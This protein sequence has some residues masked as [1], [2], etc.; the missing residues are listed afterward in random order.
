MSNGEL[1]HP[2]I[3]V[4]SVLAAITVVVLQIVFGLWVRFDYG[5]PFGQAVWIG[6]MWL[7]CSMTASV[8]FSAMFSWRRLFFGAAAFVWHVLVMSICWRESPVR[9]MLLLGGLLVL[10]ST[11]STL[12]GVPAWLAWHTNEGDLP[13]RYRFTIRSVMLGTTLVAVLLSAARAYDVPVVAAQLLAV[14]LFVLLYI[15][16]ASTMLAYAHLRIRALCLLAVL[17]GGVILY[18]WVATALSLS[19]GDRRTLRGFLDSLSDYSSDAFVVQM[20]LVQFGLFTVGC[21]LCFA[22]G[23][24]DQRDFERQ[25]VLERTLASA[26]SPQQS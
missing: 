13:R 1:T 24:I 25:Q 10:Q 6:L 7:G 26:K 5:S 21:C 18:S 23:R 11:V 3:G 20:Q 15:G 9:Y 22:L 14:P 8:C 16:S 19:V 2:R 12:L 4:L 17:F